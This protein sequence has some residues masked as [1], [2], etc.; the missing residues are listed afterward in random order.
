M[1]QE[2]QVRLIRAAL[3]AIEKGEPPLTEAFTANDPEIYT[4][5]DH[6]IRELDILFRNYPMVAG[7]SS[8]VKNPGDYFTDDLGPI[9]ILVVRGE[10]GALRAFANICRHRGSRLA[11]GCGSGVSRFVCPYHAWTYDTE[12]K[13]R[14]IP[15]DYGFEGID[16]ERHSLAHLPVEEKYGM[17]WVL[18]RAGAPVTVEEHLGGLGDDL[19]SYNLSDYVL[20]GQKVLKRRM[21]WKLVSDTFWEAYHIKVLHKTTV[22]PL[23]VKNLALFDSFGLNHRLVGIRNSITRLREVPESKWDLLPHATI[24]MNLFP[25]TICVMQT[26]HLEVYRVFPVPGS[27]SESLTEVSVLAPPASAAQPKW[28]KVLD[29]LVGVIEQDFE[30]GETIQRNFESGAIHEVVYGRY[31]AALE[32]FHHSMRNAL[33]ESEAHGW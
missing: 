31:E 18:P 19:E 23:F 33:G 30:I 6:A 27:V 17:V 11:K 1:Q 24:L 25:N 3:D 7:F 22:A 10:G 12:G 8:R 26:D 29:L 2:T 4:S 21:N 9:P 14:A 28:K 15:D 16:R 20:A 5:K 32:H 13:L